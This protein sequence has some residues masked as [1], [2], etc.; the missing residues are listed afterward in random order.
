MMKT[1]QKGFTLIELMIVI[2][3]IGIIASIA[4]PLYTNYV[5]RS[6]V[7]EGINMSTAAKV[8]ASEYFQNTGAFATSNNSAGIEAPANIIGNYVSQVQIVAGGTIQITFG[9]QAHPDIFGAVLS[10]VP[11]S[12]AGSVTWACNGD[13][14][15]P[16]KFVPAACRT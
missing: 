11:T 2:A 10:M 7:A 1:A 12:N 13:A 15:L 6:Q 4:I 3:I 9:N 14:A 16:N 5:V 8:A